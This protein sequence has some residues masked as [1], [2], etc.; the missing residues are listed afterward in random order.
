MLE[1]VH[2]ANA[3]TLQRAAG[4]ILGLVTT[5]KS[6]V[7]TQERRPWGSFAYRD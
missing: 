4:S 6:L 7:I 1:L 5:T 2:I 3:L